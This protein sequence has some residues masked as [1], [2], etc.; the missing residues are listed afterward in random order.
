MFG[1]SFTTPSTGPGCQS[2]TGDSGFLVVISSE[3]LPDDETQVNDE[4]RDHRGVHC[5]DQLASGLA[6]SSCSFTTGCLLHHFA[7]GSI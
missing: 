5:S 2:K 4:Y 1:H 6:A 7:D 3:V